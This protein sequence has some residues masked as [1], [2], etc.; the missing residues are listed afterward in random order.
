MKQE[1]IYLISKDGVVNTFNN[2]QEVFDQLGYNFLA[3]TLANEL[4]RK[5]TTDMVLYWMNRTTSRLGDKPS[6]WG[7][8]TNYQAY[9]EL[10]GHGSLK[11]F[12]DFILRNEFGECLNIFNFVE[13]SFKYQ[14]EREA[15][16]QQRRFEFWNGEGSVPGTGK[17]TYGN[18]FRHPKTLA[19]LKAAASVLDAE[20]G[21]VPVRGRRKKGFIPTA[22]DDRIKSTYGNKNWK[23]YR[24]NQYKESA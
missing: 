1:V 16:N 12:G 14:K 3:Y 15:K 13:E 18:W 10:C 17:Y 9:S 22:W 21:E 11:A 23:R 7:E 4:K 2:K 5:P 6:G 24:K 20:E 8:R 19:A